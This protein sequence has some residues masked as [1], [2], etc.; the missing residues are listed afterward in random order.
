MFKFL[1]YLLL[2]ACSTF[3]EVFIIGIKDDAQAD[4][5][6]KFKDFLSRNDAKIIQENT[7]GSIIVQLP[8]NYMSIM[9]DLMSYEVVE[10]AE[11]DQAISI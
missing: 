1:S 8:E 6:I 7:V 10:F 4:D 3:A 9:D 11:K 5:L 2:F